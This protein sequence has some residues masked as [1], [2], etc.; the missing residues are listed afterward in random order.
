MIQIPDEIL[1]RII[2]LR[3]EEGRTLRSLSSEFGY[4]RSVITR[5]I[6]K[7][8]DDLE[9]NRIKAEEHK[10]MEQIKE[11]SKE[12]EELKKEIDFL[13]KI[14]AFFAKENN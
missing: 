7:Y 14:A 5:H 4:S 13:K 2:K 12:N 10:R 1:E 3:F 9:I 11:L 8:K 6:E